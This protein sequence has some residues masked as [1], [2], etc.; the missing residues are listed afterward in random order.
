MRRVTI[1]LF[2]IT[3]TFMSLVHPSIAEENKQKEV[4]LEK[5]IITDRG[6]YIDP[7]YY[8]LAVPASEESTTSIVTSGEIEASHKKTVV[9]ALEN[10]PGVTLETQGRKYPVRIRLR[11]E[12]NINVLIN[13]SPPGQDYRILSALPSSMIEEIDVIRDSSY[14]AYGSPN[15]SSSAGTPG[16]GGVVNI[17]LKRPEREHGTEV[18]LEY[19]SF[20][21]WDQGIT[22]A[23][24]YKGVDCLFNIEHNSSD[25]PKDE[26]TN[27]EFTGITT[28]LNKNYG[29]YASK[30]NL[31]LHYDEGFIGFQKAM[32]FSTRKNDIWE[33][34]PSMN[35][36]ASLDILH[37]WSDQSSTNL[38]MYHSYQQ[39]TLVRNYVKADD[40][41]NRDIS[42]GISLRQTFLM[43]KLNTFRIGA[44][45][46]NWYCP[47]GKLF[48]E[49]NPREERDYGMYAHDE[50]RLLHDKLIIDGGIRWDQKQV[51]QGIHA[52][53]NATA[54][55][56][57]PKYYDKWLSPALN[58]AIGCTVWP[59]KKHGF[60][61][62]YSTSNQS[63]SLYADAN[64]NLLDNQEETRYDIGYIG[65]L[66]E[67]INL[68]ITGFQKNISGMP[69]YTT[70]PTGHYEPTFIKRYGIETEL[71]STLAEGLDYYLNY[72]QIYSRDNTND[73]QE[74]NIPPYVVS[75]GLFYNR[76]GWAFNTTVKR[77]C[78][79]EDNSLVT[80]RTYVRLGDYWQAD[81]NCSYEFESNN[82]M[83]TIYAGARNIGDVKYQTIPGYRDLGRKIYT[84]YKVKF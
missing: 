68:T 22:T 60:T 5:I 39:T 48:Y 79:Y 41:Q 37:A 30:I 2:I 34:D 35:A 18:K 43:P 3:A 83:Y 70:T 74:P 69:K 64:G 36:M 7:V 9:E 11:G 72:S 10:V 20:N 15:T 13:G 78:D 52:D 50:I 1:A 73:R 58:K 80:N 56:N 32:P 26:N 16:Y 82:R 14:L 51:V 55:T 45:F 76:K 63:P 28:I 46:N 31:L 77:V 57:L 25:G 27:K 75:T 4:F 12:R 66:S 49:Y 84:G 67:K 54:G 6:Y 38:N 62:R 29:N 42:S 24:K 8:P 61:T 23:G 65:K 59:F 53:E 21:S 19:G 40:I 81:L 17:K 33:Y 47:T 71:K 44:Q